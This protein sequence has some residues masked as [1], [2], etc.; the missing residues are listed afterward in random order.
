M[1]WMVCHILSW[2]AQTPWI[3]ISPAE[4]SSEMS[5]ALPNHQV[6]YDLIGSYSVVVVELVVESPRSSRQPKI[7]K[8]FRVAKLQPVLRPLVSGVKNLELESGL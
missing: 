4:H 2:L 5:T 7:A 1:P 8:K 6:M 3:D